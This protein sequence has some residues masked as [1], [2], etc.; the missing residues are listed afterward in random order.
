MMTALI[1]QVP[2]WLAAIG[3]VVFLIW[4]APSNQPLIPRKRG[5]HYRPTYLVVTLSV[6]AVII[7]LVIGFVIYRDYFK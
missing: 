1:W 4:R 2:L 3:L 5:E 7:V 6:L